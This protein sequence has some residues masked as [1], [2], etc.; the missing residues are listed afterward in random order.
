MKETPPATKYT[1]VDMLETTIQRC[2]KLKLDIRDSSHIPDKEVDRKVFSMTRIVTG[3]S[4]EMK[5]AYAVMLAAPLC[6]YYVDEYFKDMFEDLMVLFK[7][8]F[9]EEHLDCFR[10]FNINNFDTADED[11]TEIFGEF[12]K[13]Y[14]L[15]PIDIVRNLIDNHNY[16][17]CIENIAIKNAMYN[18]KAVIYANTNPYGFHRIVIRNE[19]VDMMKNSNQDALDCILMDLNLSKVEKLNWKSLNEV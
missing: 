18:Y 19:F 2:I 16:P 14:Y 1:L 5:E 3:K 12:T 13:H 9:Y 10:N 11:C 6:N 15:N 4:R 8:D 7:S 17:Y